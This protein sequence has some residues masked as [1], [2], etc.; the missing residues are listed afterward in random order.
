MAIGWLIGR[1]VY[2]AHHNPELGGEAA[3]TLGAP[4]EGEDH[5]ERQHMGSSSVALDSWVYSAFERLAALQYIRTELMGLK[6]WTRIECARLAE[7]AA[8]TLGQQSGPNAEEAARIQ[9][10]LEREFSYEIALLSG[11][12]NLTANLESVYARA[13]SISG[14][15]LSDG[16]HF[17]QTIT[18]DFGRPFERGTSGQAGGSFSAA[19]SSACR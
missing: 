10:Q 5:R 18:N 2:R 9:A 15:T 14:P 3:G 1:Q 12:R 4:E 7:E 13:V 6:P 19:A 17:G 16:Y 8:E 11:G